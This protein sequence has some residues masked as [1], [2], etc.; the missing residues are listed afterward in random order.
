MV[1][2]K[3]LRTYSRPLPIVNILCSSGMSV[4][5][6]PYG[7][8]WI[9]SPPCHSHKILFASQTFII[10]NALYQSGRRRKMNHPELTIW[11][12]QAEGKGTIHFSPPPKCGPSIRAGHRYA[13][14]KEE[15]WGELDK[16]TSGTTGTRYQGYQPGN[17]QY[18]VP[19][20]VPTWIRQ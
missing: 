1:S 3:Y 16:P 12:A 15:C 2:V 10:F 6:L 8:L 20:A 19:G 4:G 17:A 13:V 7:S 5:M 18:S 11:G 9:P 14:A